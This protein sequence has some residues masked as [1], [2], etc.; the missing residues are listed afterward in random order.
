[1]LGS[2]HFEQ[3]YSDLGSDW[4]KALRRKGGVG[5]T[6]WLGVGVGWYEV[7]GGGSREVLWS[8]YGADL[9]QR[10]SERQSRQTLQM[11]RA[12]GSAHVQRLMVRGSR[13]GAERF[14]ELEF[15]M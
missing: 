10:P 15:H 5:M 4:R 9:D 8:G 1:M 12:C 6:T 13:G 7:G 14:T 11:Q 3:M 2:G